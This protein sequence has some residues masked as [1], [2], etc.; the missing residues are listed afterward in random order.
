[1]PE[2]APKDPPWC[3]FFWLALPAP[4]GAGYTTCIKRR[5]HGGP[6]RDQLGHEHSLGTSMRIGRGKHTDR[7]YDT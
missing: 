3:L 1:M 7:R 2:W 5:G 6:C 4:P